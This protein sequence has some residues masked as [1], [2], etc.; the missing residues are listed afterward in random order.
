M[1]K[2]LT[3]VLLTGTIWSCND[4]Q[5]AEHKNFNDLPDTITHHPETSGE[6]LELNNGAKWKVDTATGNNINNL[7]VVIK[8]FDSG[9]DTSL[10]AYKKI[11]DDLQT[12]LNKTITECK[13]KGA[14]HLAL[15]KWLEP[16]LEQVTKFKLAPTVPDANEDLKVIREQLDLY[17][18]YFEL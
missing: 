6:K 4:H 13:M 18:R 3:L 2:L 8:K 9:N 11:Q 16:L 5:T 1:R 15:H 17:D 12:G 10:A 7:K 14:E